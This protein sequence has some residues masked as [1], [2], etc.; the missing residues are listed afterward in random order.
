[1]PFMRRHVTTGGLRLAVAAGLVAVLAGCG[2]MVGGGMAPGLVA[3]MDTPGATLD[4]ASSLSM[5]N[6]FRGTTGAGALSDDPALD[7]QAQS[8]AQAYAKSDKAPA[9][10]PGASGIRASAGYANFAETF[11]GWRNSPA[12]AAVLGDTKSRRAGLAAVYDAHSTYGV[13]WI[14]VLGS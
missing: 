1:M 13:Y 3:S 5:I 4:R 14:L 11:S 12:D 7:A 9:L 8:L 10:P 2:E 6:Q